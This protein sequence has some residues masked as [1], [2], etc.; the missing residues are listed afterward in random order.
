M[1][2]LRDDKTENSTESPRI[3]PP[4][5]RLQLRVMAPT[6]VQTLTLPSEGTLILG[7]MSGV[8]VRIENDPSSDR[9]LAN[10]P[11]FARDICG[12]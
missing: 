11:S 7:R 8:D 1:P 9:I 2:D 4:V 3:P 5:N 6:G 12:D 10:S